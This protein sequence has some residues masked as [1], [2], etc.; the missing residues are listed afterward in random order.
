MSYT[1][2]V[3][4]QIDADI[5]EKC[6]L[7]METF[8]LHSFLLDKFARTGTPTIFWHRY[9]GEVIPMAIRGPEFTP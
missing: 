7:W 4:L 3:I 1:A 9:F 6:H 2:Q 5:A 8:K